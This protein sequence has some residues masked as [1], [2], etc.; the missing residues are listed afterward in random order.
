MT[1]DV[2]GLNLAL[3]QRQSPLGIEVGGVS[4]VGKQASIRAPYGVARRRPDV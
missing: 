2:Y 4:T 1:A 3:E